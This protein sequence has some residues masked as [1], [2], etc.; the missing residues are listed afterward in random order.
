[1]YSLIKKLL[2]LVIPRTFVFKLEPFLR[3]FHYLLYKGSL[4]KC[5]ICNRELSR[6]QISGND[7]ICP[8]CGSLGRNRRLW[9]LLTIRFQKEGQRVL[10]F[11]PSRCIYRKQKKENVKYFPTDLSGDFIAEF[12]YDIT[13][14]EAS[15]SYFDLVICYHI[16]E[17]VINDN[18]AMSELYRVLKK[19]GKCLIQTPYKNGDIYE[20]YSVVDENERRMHFGQEDHVRIYSVEGLKRRLEEVGFVVEVLEYKEDESNRYG[21]DISEVILVCKK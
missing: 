4:Y 15:D 11:S 2:H 17:H 13:K 14:I 6:F 10:D 21:F 3:S 20:D 1:M 19:E 7:K 5:N 12:K 16:L 18:Q 9:N 8:S